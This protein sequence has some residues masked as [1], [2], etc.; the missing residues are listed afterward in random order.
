ML[1]LLRRQHGLAGKTNCRTRFMQLR[2]DCDA[3]IENETVTLIMI[4]TAFFKIFQNATI[5]L[6]DF[7][8]TFALHQRTG[9]LAS[10][11]AGAKHDD[12]SLAEFPAAAT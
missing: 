5:Q 4:A 1:L 3:M 10:N 7:L 12:R 2:I 8:K 6:V 11:A 9:F